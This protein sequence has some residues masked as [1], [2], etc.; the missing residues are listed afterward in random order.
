M[1]RA[2]ERH[3][4]GDARVVPIIVR[5]CKWQRAPFARMQALPP[6]GKAV[7]RWR[8]RDAARSKV[9]D[10]LEQILKTIPKKGRGGA[11]LRHRADV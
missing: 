2:V 1:K 9:A 3:D 6:D 10:G 11:G 8:D 7:R 5:D 4:A